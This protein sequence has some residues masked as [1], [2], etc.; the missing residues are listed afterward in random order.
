M[1]VCTSAT[2]TAFAQENKTSTTSNG[3]T[4]VL[5]QA[6]KSLEHNQKKASGVSTA[7][8]TAKTNASEVNIPEG[9]S[10]PTSKHFVPEILTVAIGTSVEWTNNDYTLHTVTSGSP[11]DEA[12]SGSEFDSSYIGAGKTFEHTF[13]FIGSFEYYCTLHPFMTGQVVVT[14]DGKPPNSKIT[15]PQSES[16]YVNDDYGV[17]IKYPSDWTVSEVNLA[18]NVIAEFRAP[19]SGNIMLEEYVSDPAY[20]VLVSK[21]LPVNNMSLTEFIASFL[22]EVFPNATDYRIIQSN[23]TTLAGME[24]E[25]IILYEYPPALFGAGS[26]KAMRNFAIDHHN[27]IGYMFKYNA[28]PGTYTKYFSAAEKMMNSFQVSKSIPGFSVN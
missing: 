11:E 22:E 20:V 12:A 9:A 25:K 8:Q 3:S 14:E 5:E 23:K 28:H 7:D 17:S 1:L 6:Q 21:K 2:S 10:S 19:M 27:G 4:T 13:I 15:V 16:K 26:Y 24:S 18:Q